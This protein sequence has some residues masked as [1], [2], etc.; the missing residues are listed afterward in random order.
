MDERDQA[1]AFKQIYEQNPLCPALSFYA[2][3]TRLRSEKI[4]SLLFL[5]LEKPFDLATTVKALNETGDI[6]NDRRRQLLSLMNC[7]YETQKAALV[8][9]VLLTPRSGQAN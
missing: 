5:V 8:N 6:R 7:I 1:E 3:L 4:R 2:G 9:Y